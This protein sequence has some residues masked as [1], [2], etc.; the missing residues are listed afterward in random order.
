MRTAGRSLKVTDPAPYGWLQPPPSLL[1]QQHSWGHTVQKAPAEHWWQLSNSGGEASE[2]GSAA[3]PCT[4]LCNNKELAGVW[5][6]GAA[7]AALTMTWC[8]TGCCNEETGSWVRSWRDKW[9]LQT[10]SWN[11]LM[12]TCPRGSRVQERWVILQEQYGSCSYTK[13]TQVYILLNFWI[14]TLPMCLQS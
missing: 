6:L 1:E 7:L 11:K 8:S 3:G 5:M 12:G 4:L 13:S 10:S 9:S 2:E 14:S